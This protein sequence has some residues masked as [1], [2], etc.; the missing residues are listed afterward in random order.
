MNVTIIVPSLDPDEKL[1]QVVE[2]LLQEGFTDI[3]LVNDGS[4]PEHREP[5]ETAAKHP[6]VTVLTHE[7][8]KGKG[9]AMKTAFAWC[10]ENRPDID[11]VV[12]VDGDNQHKPHDVR[13]CAEAMV[14][15]PAKVWLGVRDFSLPEVP[16]RS[17][18]G[19][20]LTRNVMRLFC[21]VSVTDTQT[22][23]RAIA[24]EHLPLMCRIEGERYEYE[25]EMLPALHEAGVG[26][27]E[28][29]IDTVYIDENQTSHFHPLKDSAK[30]Y[31]I[32][33]RR[34]LRKK[35]SGQ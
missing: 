34:S 20:T 26:L 1:N 4:H 6:E 9:R 25:T 32:I 23:L 22:G 24:R 18:M 19:N 2:G 13:R 15:Q 11:G 10:M 21:G 12:T 31:K 14:A 8:N 17:R 16:F 7:V 30:I 29:V 33:L 3:L 27:G 5:F 35:K 28:V